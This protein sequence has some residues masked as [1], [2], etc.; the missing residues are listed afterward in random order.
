G[1]IPVVVGFAVGAAFL[2]PTTAP[3]A[4]TASA[5]HLPFDEARL[6]SLRAANKPVFLYFTADWCLTCKANEASAIDRAE[7]RAAFEK[8]GVAVMI[9]DWTNA[10]PAITRFLE[11]QGRSGVPLYLWYAPGKEAQA[12]PQLLT[13]G[14]LTGLVR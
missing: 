7:T 13:T 9:G 3:A 2:L 1:L 6:A 11:A 8:G 10:D 12:L 5:D 14:T 4:A